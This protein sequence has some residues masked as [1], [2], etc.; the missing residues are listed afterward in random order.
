MPT[1]EIETDDGSV[2]QID[3]EEP[4]KQ[5]TATQ[6][7]P[8]MVGNVMGGIGAYLKEAQPAFKSMVQHPYEYMTGQAGNMPPQSFEDKPWSDIYREAG[9]GVLPF[10]KSQKTAGQLVPEAIGTALDIGTRPSSYLGGAI[11]KNRAAIGKHAPDIM[12]KNYTLQRATE[13]A[14]ELDT[15]RKTIGMAKKDAITEVADVVVPKFKPTLSQD[16][17]TKLKDPLYEIGFT[18]SGAIKPTIGNLDK[19]LD[20]LGDMMTGKGWIDATKKN[21]QA[22][23]QAYGY[24]ADMMRKTVPEI[25]A[26]IEAYA[27]FMKQYGLVNKTLRDTSGNVLEKKLRTAFGKDSERQAFE[28][29]KTLSGQSSKLKQIMKD[30]GKWAVRQQ[31]K[32]YG[33]MVAGAGA[34]AYVA[35]RYL[36]EKLMG[37]QR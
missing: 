16:I 21:Q 7:K 9:G 25:K 36:T 19:V 35:H 10:A 17:L 30:M 37:G 27:N 14:V 1:Y 18:K 15:L 5:T 11:F 22:I 12:G 31:V 24:I 3:T 6:E 23:K 28:A 32:K 4:T 2:Y 26:P 29:W 20:S 8:S 33:S 34:G 13:G